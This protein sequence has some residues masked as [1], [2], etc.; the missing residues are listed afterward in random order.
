MLSYSARRYEVQAA[1][2]FAELWQLHLVH[3]WQSGLD[4]CYA[5]RQLRQR[6]TNPDGG[7]VTERF[8]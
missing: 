5:V 1:R 8:P 4:I 6:E 2:V 7:C 3:E